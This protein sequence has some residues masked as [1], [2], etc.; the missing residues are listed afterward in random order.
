MRASKQGV[1]LEK[2]ANYLSRP[3]KGGTES[4][5]IEKENIPVNEGKAQLMDIIASQKHGF[6]TAAPLKQQS[7]QRGSPLLA[8]KYEVKTESNNTKLCCSPGSPTDRRKR[9]LTPKTLKELL[10][11]RKKLGIGQKSPSDQ[12]KKKPIAL[13][14]TELLAQ[15]KFRGQEFS[16]KEMSLNN[17]TSTPS[18]P[19]PAMDRLFDTK[20]RQFELINRRGRHMTAFCINHPEKR[21]KFAV[22]EDSRVVERDGKAAFLRG[23]CSKCAVRIANAGF[24]I[25]EIEDDDQ[26]ALKRAEFTRFIGHV[27]GVSEMAA[28][29]LQE[30]GHRRQLL[31]AHYTRQ[32]AIVD[33][34]QAYLDDVCQ[35]ARKSLADTKRGLALDADHKIAGLCAQEAA[36]R[37]RQADLRM[38]AENL[39]DNFLE[40][41]KV[42]DLEALQNNVQRFEQQLAAISEGCLRSIASP[43]EVAVASKL[44][45]RKVK[46]F[47]EL[48]LGLL[49]ISSQQ[50]KFRE[51]E[52]Y[53][54]DFFHILRTIS[55]SELAQALQKAGD[56]P[57][58]VSFDGTQ[59]QV[60]NLAGQSMHAVGGV[61]IVASKEIRESIKKD[62]EHMDSFSKKESFYDSFSHCIGDDPLFI[63]SP[64]EADFV[65]KQTPELGQKGV[66][67]AYLKNHLSNFRQSSIQGTGTS[68]RCNQTLPKAKTPSKLDTSGV[69]QAT[70][71]ALLDI[72]ELFQYIGNRQPLEK[73]SFQTGTGHAKCQKVLFSEANMLAELDQDDS[74]LDER[75]L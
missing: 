16:H 34:L 7:S 11:E 54:E 75:L 52:A 33:G 17:Q 5:Y 63:L 51:L 42:M 26:E 4:F 50:I 8:S 62:Q 66:M 24:K 41:V 22:I 53:S 1:L 48:S 59:A 67:P 72:D 65:S 25:D 46:E 68:N 13:R 69:S 12:D 38:F 21:S 44:D 9:C 15:S 55:N 29:S 2:T 56:V 20:G 14:I 27:Q 70:S 73:H 61:S 64:T 30:L 60:K 58:Y 37:H 6:S 36:L 49:Q 47:E 35:A 71:S 19:G 32:T 10:G 43:L 23:V 18:S 39:G 45:S 40:T 31:A 57:V 74:A 28:V 3:R